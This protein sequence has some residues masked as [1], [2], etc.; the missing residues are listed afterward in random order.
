MRTSLDVSH[1]QCDQI[2]RFLQVL[3]Y[4]LSQKSSPKMWVTFWATSKNVTIM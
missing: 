3:G 2:G 1:V 4:K